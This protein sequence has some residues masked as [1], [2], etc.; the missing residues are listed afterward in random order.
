MSKLI[1]GFVFL[2]ST[3]IF[4]LFFNLLC[5]EFMMWKNTPVLHNKWRKLS[6]VILVLLIC[7]FIGFW[8][9]NFRLQILF[10][11]PIVW[12]MTFSVYVYPKN[13]M[14]FTACVDSGLYLVAT[15][16]A[17]YLVL[18]TLSEKVDFFDDYMKG[19]WG[20]AI[21]NFFA[22]VAAMRLYVSFV[23]MINQARQ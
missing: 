18:N 22:A 10:I 23:N 7:D 2:F 3:V 15:I 14:L 16:T 21:T 13:K 12:G 9:L 1:R 19:F 20:F 4:N 8:V 11:L 5:S 6:N 17:A